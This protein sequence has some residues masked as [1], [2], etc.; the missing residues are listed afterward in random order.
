MNG[1]ARGFTKH[2]CFFLCLCDSHATALHYETIE[3]LTKNSYVFGIKI[4]Q[5]IP[6]VNF[7]KVLMPLLYI[8]LGLMKKFVKAMAKHC[9]NGFEFLCKNFPN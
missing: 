6:L 5:H 7:N 9:L 2:F 3:W 1:I 8:K 4:I